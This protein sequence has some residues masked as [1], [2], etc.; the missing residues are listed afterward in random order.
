MVPDRHR[1]LDVP[2]C[3]EIYRL[4]RPRCL[5]TPRFWPWARPGWPT[6]TIKP[7]TMRWSAPLAGPTAPGT[8][9]PGQCARARESR[10]ED[11]RRQTEKG[12]QDG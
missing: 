1:R 5:H 10:G 4:R 3:Y 7:G 6:C 12:D 8:S 2:G 9:G 11:L